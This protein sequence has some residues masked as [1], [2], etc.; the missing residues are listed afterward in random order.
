MPDYLG[1][2]GFQHGTQEKLGVLLANLGTPDAPET[3]ALRR[4]L[5]EFLWDPRVVEAPRALWWFRWGA[6]FTF[7]SGWTIVLMKLGHGLTLTA[8]QPLGALGAQRPQ[9]GGVTLVEEQR[10]GLGGVDDR[11]LPIVVHR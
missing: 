6:M 1:S 5:A 11:L 2:E 10:V 4:Y 9:R 3:G 8:L 7:L